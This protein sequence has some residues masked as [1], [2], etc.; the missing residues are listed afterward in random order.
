MG[1]PCLLCTPKCGDLETGQIAFLRKEGRSVR[2]EWGC[3]APSKPGAMEAV[4]W[5]ALAFLWTLM[6]LPRPRECFALP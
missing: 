1:W 3:P 5:S 4:D 2:A 6:F